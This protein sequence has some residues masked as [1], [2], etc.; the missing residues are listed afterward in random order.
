MQDNLAVFYMLVADGTLCCVPLQL[1][2]TARFQAVAEESLRVHAHVLAG[3]AGPTHVLVWR[4]APVG[5]VETAADTATVTFDIGFAIGAAAAPG[6]TA[7]KL[8]GAAPDGKVAAD[9]PAVAGS[10]WTMTV[11]SIPT[12]VVLPALA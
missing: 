5:D 7:W 1:A 9:V 8:S 2:G 10:Q 12:L 6:L 3:V 11:S 4:P